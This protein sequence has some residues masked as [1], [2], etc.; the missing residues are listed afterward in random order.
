[1]GKEGDVDE[2]SRYHSSVEKL[3]AL[4]NA[5]DQCTK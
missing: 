4:K 3:E 5:L 1:M 2:F